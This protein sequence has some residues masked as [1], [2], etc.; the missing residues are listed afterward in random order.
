MVQRVLLGLLGQLT[1]P[2]RYTWIVP[3]EGAE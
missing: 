1:L 2:V 3:P